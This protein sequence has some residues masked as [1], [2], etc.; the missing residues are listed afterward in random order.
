MIDEA[1]GVVEMLGSLST[2]AVA[3]AAALRRQL[4]EF[5]L[6]RR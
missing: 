3:T 1:V 2:T 5:R 4:L 6:L